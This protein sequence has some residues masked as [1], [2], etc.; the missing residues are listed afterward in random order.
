M[1]LRKLLEE[2]DISPSDEAKLYESVRAFY[3]L[4][5]EYALKNLPINDCLLKNAR[6]FNFKSKDNA[7]F[8]QVEYFVERL[9]HLVMHYMH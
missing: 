1:C 4:A 9:V 3:V 6:F 8:S 7:A 2:G 5:M